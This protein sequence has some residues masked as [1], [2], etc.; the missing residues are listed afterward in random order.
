VAVLTTGSKL[1]SV[2]A[3]K[4]NK[5]GKNVMKTQTTPILPV[6]T[7]LIPSLLRRQTQGR[8][9]PAQIRAPQLL[10]P[11]PFTRSQED[12]ELNEAKVINVVAVL[13]GLVDDLSAELET[14]R[15]KRNAEHDKTLDAPIDR[16]YDQV[17]ALNA[18]IQK[19]IDNE[20]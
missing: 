18:L 15:R 10:T 7:Q 5:K 12:D 1:Y 2:T 14:L 3:F 8:Q 6:L 17:Q 9:A 20:T 11:N 19:E 13:R 16:I 4:T